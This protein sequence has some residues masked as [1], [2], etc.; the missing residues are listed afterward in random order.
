MSTSDTIAAFESGYF[1]LHDTTSIDSTSSCHVCMDQG[2]KNSKCLQIISLTKFARTGNK[3]LLYWST[4][5]QSDYSLEAADTD[6]RRG[7]GSYSRRK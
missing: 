3:T 6:D 7:R 5:N 1:D 4:R 2:H